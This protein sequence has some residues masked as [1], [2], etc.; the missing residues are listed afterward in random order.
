M[1]V[2]T[3]TSYDC[4]HTYKQDQSCHRASC[5]G[6]E[7]YHFESEGDCRQCKKDGEAVSR[8]REGQGRYARELYKKDHQPPQ[9][10]IPSSSTS[11]NSQ[12]NPWAPPSKREREW[13]SPIRKQADEAWEEEHAR[14][15]QDLQNRSP[16]ITSGD[17]TSAELTHPRRE[18]RGREDHESTIRDE[19][20]KQ[21][22]A[23]RLRARRRR[24]RQASY[25][26]FDSIGESYRSYGSGQHSCGHHSHGQCG[27][28]EGRSH[29]SGGGRSR[30][31]DSGF[32]PPKQHSPYNVY[33]TESY[34][35]GLGQG[36][37]GL[38]KDSGWRWARW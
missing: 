32:S 20:Q 22:D 29:E 9:I 21:E 14:R 26:S 27:G 35:S 17:I 30:M 15:E 8:G 28:S 11:H 37:G 13:H 16:R 1:C 38:V 3:K 7:R 6:L 4:G 19:V 2:R 18:S 25:D 36:L 12:S 34:F 5:P 24:E 33:N 31:Y 10:R 23:R